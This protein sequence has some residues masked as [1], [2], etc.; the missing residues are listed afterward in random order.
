MIDFKEYQKLKN[1][2]YSAKRSYEY[3]VRYLNQAMKEFNWSH[4]NA[5]TSSN[6][7][8]TEDSKITETS[9]AVDGFLNL[10]VNTKDYYDAKAEFEKLD[11][12]YKRQSKILELKNKINNYIDWTSR[13]TP[14][15]YT[16][17]LEK[18]FDELMELIK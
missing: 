8:T 15:D 3:A 11:E 9:I 18:S 16:D 5:E 10:V 4:E 12:E 13:S 7:D 1:D 2:W 6:E 17:D 14:N